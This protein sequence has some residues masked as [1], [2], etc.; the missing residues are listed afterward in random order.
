MS[1]LHIPSALLIFLTVMM[2]IP[3][4]FSTTQSETDQ[5]HG[6][7]WLALLVAT[8]ICEAISFFN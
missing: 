8:V 1:L 5:V 2:F 4:L 7:T 6:A 3:V